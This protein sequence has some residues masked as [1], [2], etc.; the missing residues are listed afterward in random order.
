[1]DALNLTN[2]TYLPRPTGPEPAATSNGTMVVMMLQ[3]EDKSIEPKLDVLDWAMTMLAGVVVG[4]RVYNKYRTR[5]R[6]WWDDW[7]AIVSWVSFQSV[8]ND[9]S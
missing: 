1:M 9:Y 5:C 3:A 4:L 7:I 6:L 2:T 8:S